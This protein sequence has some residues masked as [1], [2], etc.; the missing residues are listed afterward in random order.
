MKDYD[1]KDMVILAVLLICIAAM[2]IPNI[3]PEA[4][5]LLEKAFYGLFGIAVGRATTKG[6]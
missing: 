1:D 3:Q 5:S 4:F 6:E 2:A